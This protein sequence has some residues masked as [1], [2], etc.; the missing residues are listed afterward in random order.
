MTPSH[1]FPLVAT[2]KVVSAPEVRKR[3]VKSALG[4]GSS[5]QRK[6]SHLIFWGETGCWSINL[7]F[8]YLENK[9]VTDL[10]FYKTN[11]GDRHLFERHSK[12]YR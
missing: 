12:S 9:I 11:K 8:F 7:S 3:W 5:S 1:S 10:H 6:N 2:R 4:Q